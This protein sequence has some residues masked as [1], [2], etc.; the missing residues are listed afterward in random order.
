MYGPAVSTK[1]GRKRVVLAAI[2]DGFYA[3]QTSMSYARYLLSI[4]LGRRLD[5]KEHVDHIDGDPTNDSVEN[6]QI[7]SSAA[8]TQKYFKDHDL[9]AKERTLTCAG[10]GVVF[11]RKESQIEPNN[12]NHFCSVDCSIVYPKKRRTKLPKPRNPKIRVTKIAWPS[13]DDLKRLVWETPVDALAK[14]WGVSGRAIAKRCKN[15]NI[16]VPPRGYW[17]G[18]KPK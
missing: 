8:N 18:R 15:R 10:C 9:Y 7:L 13:D 3:S 14:E 17:T 5:P 1:D 11:N 12:K 2:D 6:L 4:K 16:S